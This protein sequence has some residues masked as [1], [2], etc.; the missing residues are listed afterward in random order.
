[1]RIK[2]VKSL[3]IALKK[4]IGDE[5]RCTD[6]P[7]DDKPGMHVTI[8]CDDPNSDEWTYQTGDN[9]FVGSCYHYRNWSV[10]YLY[11][12]S[13][14]LELAKYAIDQLHELVAC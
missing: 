13:N 5:F 10:V 11:R 7:D 6:E 4:D 2:D 3:L 9:S 1:M 12:D 8:A 14:C